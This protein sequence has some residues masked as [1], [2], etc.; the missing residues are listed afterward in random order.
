M[1]GGADLVPAAPPKLSNKGAKIK[2]VQS[3]F[4]LRDGAG[5]ENDIVLEDF[6]VS[7]INY[8]V[9][10]NKAQNITFSQDRS[11]RIPN[12]IRKT[13]KIERDFASDTTDVKYFNYWYPFMERWQYWIT[14]LNIT[15]PPSGIFDPSMPLNGLNNFW[16]RF[17]TVA[18]W[19]LW[20]DVILTLEQNGVEFQQTFS[21]KLKDSN[22]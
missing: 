16:Y 6:S 8:P 2:R 13:I 1:S 12:E 21:S 14:L 5:I 4:S 17:T 18:D 15:A 22:D 20:Y 3:R 11:Y 7:V 9:I 10:G 19:H